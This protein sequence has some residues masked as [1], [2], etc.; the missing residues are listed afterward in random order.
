MWTP[1]LHERSLSILIMYSRALMWMRALF[2]G[3]AGKRVIAAACSLT[4]F[5]IYL[6]MSRQQLFM[7]KSVRADLRRYHHAYSEALRASSTL[8][9]V[10]C[11]HVQCKEQPSM[12]QLELWQ[13][14]TLLAPAC[15]VLVLPSSL[16]EVA[17]ELNL[18]V[19]PRKESKIQVRLGARKVPVRMTVFVICD[20]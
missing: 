17:G 4:A 15:G 12:M 13:H 6:P 1:K 16:A 5:W 9:Q 11:A 7:H 20:L 14:H 18:W 19:D 8:A 10:V 3:S 2:Q